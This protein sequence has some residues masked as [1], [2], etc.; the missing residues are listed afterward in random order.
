MKTKTKIEKQTH[1]KRNSELVETTRAAK[2]KEKWLEVA[3]ILSG[4]R[5]KRPS[6]NLTEINKSSTA[7]DTV[8]VPGKVLSQGEI[9]KKINETRK[10]EKYRERKSKKRDKKNRHK[11]RA[12]E[13]QRKERNKDK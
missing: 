2:K 11:Q 5:R 8:V 6:L 13:K 9:D 10:G 1:R 7:G 12:R 3:G 4:P